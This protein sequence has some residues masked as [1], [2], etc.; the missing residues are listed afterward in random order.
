MLRMRA[1][2]P[3]HHVVLHRLAQ[4]VNRGGCRNHIH[5]KFLLVEGTP[6][7]SGDSAL[8]KVQI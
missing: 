1:K 2:T 6:P 4:R 3:H 8:P 7:S 5:G